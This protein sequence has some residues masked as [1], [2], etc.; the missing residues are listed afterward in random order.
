MKINWNSRSTTRAA[1]ALIVALIAILFYS[2]LN[3]FKA[4]NAWFAGLITPITPIFAGLVMAYLLCPI[5]EKFELFASQ[6]W[7]A[8]SSMKPRRRRTISLCVTYLFALTIVVGFLWIVLPRVILS[9]AQMAAQI[10][11]YVSLSEDLVNRLVAKIPAELITDDVAKQLQDFA[12][13]AV[14]KFISLLNTSL[15]ALFNSL[16]YVGNSVINFFVGLI[17]SIYV[18]TE[19]EGF[20]ARSKK[21]IYAMLPQS[22]AENFLELLRT[23]DNMF[24]RFIT[25]KILDSLLIGILCFIGV[26]IMQMPNAVL[27][28]FIIGVTNII[29]YFGPFIGAVP[30]FFLIAIVSPMKAVVFIV[31]LFILQQ[32]DGN[33]I[34]PKILGNS[35]GLSAFWVVFAILFFG[36]A[37]GI[38]GMVIGVPL[39][40]VIYWWFKLIVANRLAEKGLPIQ[41][42]CYLRPGPPSEEPH[43]DDPAETK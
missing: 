22:T 17:V 31:F 34:G 28:S 30:A 5:L 23:A 37:L 41:T 18:L 1:Y 25:G 29:P 26:S 10:K 11:T 42:D 20:G 36:G 7:K 3:H 24:G 6:H 38:R 13:T 19:K 39:F 2:W 33:V 9:V 16:I 43:P 8:Y 21:V 14:Q 27:V 15:P 4:V 40:G 35:T 32:I 12:G